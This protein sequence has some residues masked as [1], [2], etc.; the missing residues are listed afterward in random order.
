MKTINLIVRVTDGCNMRCKYCYNSETGYDRTVLP[1]EK[2]EKLLTLLA[3]D[4]NRINVVWHGGEPLM[5][6][7]EYFEKA[8]EIEKKLSSTYGYLSFANSVQTNGSLID[9]EWAK[10]FAKNDFKPGISFDGIDND[11]YRGQTQKILAAMKLL[12]KHG[13]KFG[14]LAVVADENYDLK[15]NYDYFAKLGA[16]A[17]FSPVFAEGAGKNAEQNNEKFARDMI[18]LFDYWLYDKKGVAIRTFV[19]YL[20]MSMGYNRRICTNASCIGKFLSV[21]PDGTLFNCNRYSVRQ[22]PFA[23]VDEVNSAAEIF[24]GEKFVQFVKGSIER[25]NKCKAQCELF[26]KCS[27]GCAD[28]AIAEGNLADIPEHGCYLFRKLY[29]HV[30]LA[31]EKIKKEKISLDELNP[32]VKQMLVTCAAIDHNEE[33]ELK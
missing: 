10:F 27:G 16:G 12:K 33:A 11:K 20:S 15:A 21:A 29:P 14:L 4:Y 31:A 30:A 17:E 19:S 26:D 2:I 7:K 8:V 25:R 22:Y 9:A 24:A 3:K 6:G 5:A 23:H 32:A 1:L 13:V 18:D 28:C